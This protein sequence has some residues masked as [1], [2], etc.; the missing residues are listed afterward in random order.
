MTYGLVTMGDSVSFHVT[1]VTDTDGLRAACET[2]ESLL[3]QTPAASGFQSAAWVTHCWVSLR[4]PTDRLYTAIVVQ[5]DE[6]VALFPMQ[7]SRRGRMTF[8]GERVSNYS[9]PVYRADR[10]DGSLAAWIDHVNAAPQVKTLD[11]SGLREQSPVFRALRA[12][13]VPRWGTPLATKTFVCPEADLTQGWDELYGRHSRKSRS[14]WRRKE[15]RLA[16]LGAV[17]IVE[18][19]DPR[20][21]AA[22]FPHLA[23]L[24]AARWEGKRV[25]A[26]L[27]GELERFHADAAVAAAKAGHVTLALLTLDGEIIAF[28]YGIRANGVTASCML[29]H[30]AMFDLHSA[31]LLLLK[32]VLQTAA[33]RGDPMYDFSLGR[34]DYKAKWATRE[35]SV[36][37]LVWGSG[38]W[39]RTIW[40]RTW[41]SARSHPVLRRAKQDGVRALLG[42]QPQNRALP[43]V[44]GLAVDERRSWFVYRIAGGAASGAHFVAASYG[45]MRRHLSPRMLALAVERSFRGDEL[46]MTENERGLVG[47]VWRASGDRRELVLAGHGRRDT[48]EQVYYQPTSAAGFAPER[49]VERLTGQHP[50]LVVSAQPLKSTAEMTYV[51]NFDA[52]TVTSGPLA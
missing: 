37:R 51:C 40:A 47:V 22:A 4:G 17:N 15:R 13:P 18:T 5:G 50:C 3:A 10:L 36:F 26:G 25:G 7:L 32:S 24:Y 16:A 8:I 14:T 35:Q 12:R 39:P 29:A 23:R 49:L 46:L 1:I 30:D 42:R 48:E 34:A 52:D 21:V 27:A 19:E 2:W 33:N 41:I 31:G 44:P 38:K 6:P 20:E 9:G 28:S 11:L 45:D 43:D